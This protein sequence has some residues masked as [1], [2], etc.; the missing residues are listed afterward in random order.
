MN[1][2]IGDGMGHMYEVT[3]SILWWIYQGLGFLFGY[4]PYWVCRDTCSVLVSWFGKGWMALRSYPAFWSR[5][6]HSTPIGR[7]PEKHVKLI[8][9]WCM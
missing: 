6:Y 8:S 5:L 3:F 4:Q 7:Y 2:T 9:H 1:G